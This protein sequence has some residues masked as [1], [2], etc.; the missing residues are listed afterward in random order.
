MVVEGLVKH[1]AVRGAMP[2]PIVVWR[3]QYPSGR[4]RVRS[5]VAHAGLA[6]VCCLTFCRA[7][8]LASCT[9]VYPGAEKSGVHGKRL[10]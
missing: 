8:A 6:T 5:E 7:C 2:L 9:F 1:N 10:T 4:L 3:V